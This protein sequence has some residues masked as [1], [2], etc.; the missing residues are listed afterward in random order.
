MDIE[1]L[2]E[3]ERE[4]LR[5]LLHPM[6]AKSI[7]KTLDLSTYTVNDHLKNARAKLGVSDSLTAAYMLRDYES[8]HPQNVGSTESGWRDAEPIGQDGPRE[9]LEASTLPRPFAVKGRPWNR[10]SMGWRIVWLLLLFGIVALGAGLL[11]GSIASLSQFLLSV[12]R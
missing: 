12:S 4:C 10:L 3:R 2:S 6:R 7:A 9:G 11:L 1:R 8:G 5:L